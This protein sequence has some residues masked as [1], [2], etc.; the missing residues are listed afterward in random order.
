MIHIYTSGNLD[1]NLPPT[2]EQCLGPLPRARTCEIERDTEG[3]FDLTLTCDLEEYNANNLQVGNWLL[4]PVGGKLPQQYFCIVQREV[5][6]QRQVTVHANHVSYNAADVLAAPFTAEKSANADSVA[7]LPWY[8]ALEAATWKVSHEQRGKLTVIGYTDAMELNAAR[9]T[10][11]VSMRQAVQ[12]AVEGRDLLLLADNFNLKIWQA[13]DFANPDF[14]IRY[15]SNMM[16]YSGKNAREDFYTHIL[17]YYIGKEGDFRTYNSYTIF[18]LKNL[19]AKYAG[20][21]KIRAVDLT[22]QY[23]MTSGKDWDLGVFGDTIDVWL[24]LHPYVDLPPEISVAEVPSAG[25]VYEL[26]A[27]GNIYTP[28]GTA[29][30]VTVVSMRYD[31]LRDRVTSIGI[32]RIRRTLSDAIADIVRKE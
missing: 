26:G 20:L 27:T 16:D 11:P 8:Q 25:N 22:G 15:G 9:Y 18:P 24:K 4:A 32:D 1:R 2:S 30:R 13:A 29:N 14:S 31:A 7:F 19:P 12:D 3:L 23:G 5:S 6:V 28:D 17:P 10:A 21:K